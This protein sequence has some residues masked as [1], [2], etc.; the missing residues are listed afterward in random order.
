M[1]SGVT[2]VR[3][4]ISTGPVL[5]VLAVAGVL[6]A[7]PVLHERFDADPGEDIR[8]GAKTAGGQLPAAMDTQSGVVSAPDAGQSERPRTVYGG[9]GSTQS[10]TSAGYQIDRMT[11]Q[12]DI[13]HYD[14]PFSPSIVPF[15]RLFA[16]DQVGPELDLEV[17]DKHLR[18]L[19]V[20]GSVAPGEDA[21]YGDLTTDLVRGVPVRIPSVGPGAV[22]RALHSDPPAALQVVADGADNWF[23][24]SDRTVRARLL[25]QVSVRRQVFGSP[26]ASVDWSTLGQYVRPLPAN[27]HQAAD[28]VLSHI[29]VST[30]ESPS[31]ALER[32]V[33]YFRGFAPSGDIPQATGT[34]A[35]YEELA[36]S[37]KGVCRHRA[38]AFLITAQRL[39]LPS[40]LVHN[41][42]HAWVEV[43][44]GSLWHRI[45]LGGAAGALDLDKPKDVPLHRP[46]PDRFA[47]PKDASPGL[48]LSP[49]PGDSSGSGSQ[50][51]DAQ[52]GAG[53]QSL[54]GSHGT[55]P[56]ERRH[57]EVTLELGGKDVRRGHPLRV[58]GRL[59]NEGRGCAFARVD[60][61]L[62]AGNGANIVLGSLATDETGRYA[63]EVVVPLDVPVGDEVIEAKSAAG[64]SCV[65]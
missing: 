26:F 15:K 61:V 37:R 17:S 48:G 9:A 47:W 54:S 42:A 10:S 59:T 23:V 18:T 44:D 64:G 65:H 35:L 25:M 38:Y 39:G 13:V 51:T 32:L 60:L 40:R 55:T 58:F 3:L 16:F 1:L 36:L 30:N 27:V 41:E 7:A 14:E 6:S 12:P 22:L 8:R 33:G 62:Q 11:T 52:S 2:K 50:S 24:V 43:Y 56:P 31:R 34:V 46:P 28:R 21:F 19:P 53:T 57:G 63:G 49:S 20:G 45:D 29:G 4:W 5:A